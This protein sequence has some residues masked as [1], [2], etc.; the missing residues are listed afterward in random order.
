MTTSASLANSISC[1][2]VRPDF[3]P[4]CKKKKHKNEKN[5][6][7][8]RADSA[9]FTKKREKNKKKTKKKPDILSTDQ[10]PQTLSGL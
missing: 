7:S 1:A 4:I 3:D 5:K 10:L 9:Y 6:L 8:S 2:F